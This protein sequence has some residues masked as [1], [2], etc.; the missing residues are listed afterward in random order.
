MVIKARAPAIS[1]T[2]IIPS[3]ASRTAGLKDRAR[4]SNQGAVG[5]VDPRG[6]QR[7]PGYEADVE[8]TAFSIRVDNDGWRVLEFHHPLRQAIF[9]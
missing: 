6:V 8:V 4:A 2:L 7:V 5:A 9:V 3:S 1:T